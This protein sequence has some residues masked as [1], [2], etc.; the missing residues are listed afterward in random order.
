MDCSHALVSHLCFCWLNHDAIES[1]RIQVLKIDFECMLGWVINFKT[2]DRILEGKDFS[3]T[4]LKLK[5]KHL[6]FLI[7]YNSKFSMFHFQFCSCRKS[8]YQVFQKRESALN[9]ITFKKAKTWT[10]PQIHISLLLLEGF[11]DRDL[12]TNVG[13]IK[14]GKICFLFS[15]SK[16]SLTNA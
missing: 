1:Q 15:V 12:V 7:D 9:C 3:G 2:A 8:T 10:S 5:H 14:G 11:T 16:S 6:N 13:L 4:K